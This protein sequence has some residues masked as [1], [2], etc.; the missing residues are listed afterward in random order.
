MIYSELSETLD[1]IDLHIKE[2]KLNNIPETDQ[3]CQ[4]KTHH[5]CYR[6]YQLYFG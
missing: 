5:S 2:D 1:Y 6:Q 3:R 4:E